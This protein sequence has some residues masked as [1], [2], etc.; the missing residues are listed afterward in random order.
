MAGVASPSTTPE[1]PFQMSEITVR[2][3]GP[4][5]QPDHVTPAFIHSYRCDFA[6]SNP[7]A[8]AECYCPAPGEEPK[9]CGHLSEVACEC[10]DYDEAP[11]ARTEM[12]IGLVHYRVAIGDPLPCG[13]TDVRLSSSDPAEVT[14][15]G[16]GEVAA[17]AP[18]E[19]ERRTVSLEVLT[20]EMLRFVPPGT[21]TELLVAT[22]VGIVLRVSGEP[23][24]VP[25]TDVDWPREHRQPADVLAQM[26]Q[27]ARF[28]AS[29]A[30][31]G[32]LLMPTP[33][34][35]AALSGSTG[36]TFWTGPVPTRADAI[37]PGWLVLGFSG[38]DTEEPVDA[39]TSDCG[40]ETC[41]WPGDCTA[42]SI[43]G[44][45]PIHFADWTTLT[46]RIPAAVTR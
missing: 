25:E 2:P 22:T 6:L 10:G 46:V 31:D 26:L 32:E 24:A 19:A 40:A 9:R 21:Y 7:P 1:G 13:A 27:Q 4:E 29:D 18:V 39:K 16:C 37:E 8:D 23:V 5:G 12:Q 17:P 36:A 42:L 43:G 15:A 41:P 35:L 38:P 30:G 44:S 45:E 34:V 11:D 20:A 14:C 33:D 28:Y 3:D